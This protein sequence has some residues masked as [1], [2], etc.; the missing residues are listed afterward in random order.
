M[1]QAVNPA[2]AT[3][4]IWWRH[5]YQLSGKPCTIS[6]SGPSP[7]T[8]T[9]RRAAP[10]STILNSGM[11]LTPCVAARLGG[12]LDFLPRPGRPLL[13]QDGDVGF[14]GEAERAQHRLAVG[15]GLGWVGGAVALLAARP[16]P[17]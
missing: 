3:G 6:A 12:E 17:E 8:A 5:E 16:V 10:A 14:D 15:A 2:A 11:R 9:R 1:A 7:S 13:G 4:P